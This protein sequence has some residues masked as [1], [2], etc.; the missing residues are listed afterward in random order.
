MLTISLTYPIPSTFAECKYVL[1]VRL[2]SRN[3][4]YEGKGPSYQKTHS[5]EQGSTNFSLN[6]QIV[7]ILG[8]EGHTVSALNLLLWHKSCHRQ[9]TKRWLY[10]NKPSFTKIGSQWTAVCLQSLH[11]STEP[12]ATVK[13]LCNIQCGSHQ[14]HIATG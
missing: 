3:I 9:Y 11:R 12:Y 14:L 2:H 8:F 7:N 4:T 13:C 1:I 5:A 6:C 10:S